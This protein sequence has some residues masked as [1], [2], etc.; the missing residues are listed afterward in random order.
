VVLGIQEHQVINPALESFFAKH[1]AKGMQ[2]ETSEVQSNHIS[3]VPH[4][5]EVVKLIE[6][7]ARS[8]MI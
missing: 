3:L 6:E 4:P 2:A 5:R 7:S 8:T 1:M